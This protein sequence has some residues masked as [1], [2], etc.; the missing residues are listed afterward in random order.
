MHGALYN[1]LVSD[2]NKSNLVLDLIKSYQYPFAIYAHPNSQLINLAKPFFEVVPEAFIDRNY[3]SDGTLA[4]RTEKNALIENSMLA[5][6]HLE[7]MVEENR[8]MIDIDQ[9]IPLVAK[10]YCIHG[11][12]DFAIEILKEIQNQ[13]AK[14]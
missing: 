3:N 10:T 14:K 12:N 5:W 13:I 9:F 6:K 4:R 8:I 1:D 2:F 11:D 7:R